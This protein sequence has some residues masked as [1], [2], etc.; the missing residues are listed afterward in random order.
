MKKIVIDYLY[1]DLTLCERCQGTLKVLEQAIQAT[2]KLLEEN[3]YIITLN[4]INVINE[5]LAEEYRFYSSPTIRINGNDISYDRNESNCKE[6]G[7][8][9]GD[10]VDCRTWIY[11]NQLFTTPPI[12]MLKEKII[13]SIDSY[14]EKEKIFEKY[15]LPENLKKYFDGRKK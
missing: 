15:E 9:C 10:N 13:E 2:Q 5:E 3:N 6:C 7:D 11:N 8:L 4:K 12:E 1:L 14:V